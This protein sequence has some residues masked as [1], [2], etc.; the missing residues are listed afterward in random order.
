M[1]EGRSRSLWGH[2]SAV[3]CLLANVNRDPKKT[4]PF[5]PSDFDPHMQ[6]KKPK[7]KPIKVSMRELHAMMPDLV[8]AF[9]GGKR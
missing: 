6:A 2:T 3:L 5:K 1:A 8:D 4:Q 9:S 7:E